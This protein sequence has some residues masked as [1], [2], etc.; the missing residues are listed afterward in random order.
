MYLCRIQSDQLYTWSDEYPE[1]AHCRLTKTSQRSCAPTAPAASGPA[2][3][4]H[5]ALQTVWQAGMQMHRRPRP[6]S[7]V[8][9]VD[10]LPQRCWIVSSSRRSCRF[11]NASG[12]GRFLSIATGFRPGRSTHQAV[13]EA[14]QH[15]VEGHRWVVD[16]DLEK[17]F[18]RVNHDK[19]M[20]QVAKRI[21][22]SRMRKLIR[23][24]L[25]AGVMENGLVS[26]TV[27]GTPQGGP[28]TPRT[29]KITSNLSGGCGSGG[30][31]VR[32]D[33]CRKRL[34]VYDRCRAPAQPRRPSASIA[35]ESCFGKSINF[36]MRPSDWR[37]TV[38]FRR[39]KP[40]ATSNTLSN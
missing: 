33:V 38:P 23:A 40:T 24:F 7:Q 12:T 13:S 15:I 39:V 3:L 14:Q 8:L 30:N 16:L 4:P 29:Q 34:Y 21:T 5:R 22:D 31:R 32:I 2:R 19:L 20:G 36:P 35:H 17:F 37:K 18:D 28:I 27:E 25:N 10:K 6:W 11:Y 1:R 9:S 26:P